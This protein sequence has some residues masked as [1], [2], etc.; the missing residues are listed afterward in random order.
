MGGFLLTPIGGR[1]TSVSLEHGFWTGLK[2]I[3]SQRG[4]TS[5]RDQQRLSRRLTMAAISPRDDTSALPR[6]LS[7]PR[8]SPPLARRPYHSAARISACHG[9]EDFVDEGNDCR[10]FSGRPDRASVEGRRHGRLWRGSFPTSPAAFHAQYRGW[11]ERAQAGHPAGM[12]AGR[13]AFA[14]P[15]GTC[16]SAR[17][18]RSERRQQRCLKYGLASV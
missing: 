17:G 3:A 2:E 15:T 14:S 1:K 18:D 9:A 7:D 10:G 6:R 12:G 11:R 5:E 13:R 8:G 16:R 4:V